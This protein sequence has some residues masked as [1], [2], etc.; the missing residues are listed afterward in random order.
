MKRKTWIKNKRGLLDPK[1]QTAIG[2]AIWLYLYLI[3]M[4]DWFTGVVSNYTD[5]QAADDLGIPQPTIRKQRYRLQNAKYIDSAKS[6]HKQYVMIGKWTN[7]RKYDG[8]VINDP[9]DVGAYLETIKS[10]HRWAVLEDEDP[11][12]VH[13]S[14]HESV[15]ESVHES[16]H[17]LSPLLLSHISQSHISQDI[18]GSL[19]QD[20]WVKALMLIKQEHYRRRAGDFDRYWSV[21]GYAGRHNGK[22]RVVCMGPDQRQ[23]LEDRGKKIAENILVGILGERVEIEFVVTGEI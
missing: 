3:D 21:T 16:V 23:W 6:R 1:H 11:E 17:E 5:G 22:Y 8:Q 12:S 2:E 10:G 18:G 7:P 15:R 9:P 14:V 13:E 19:S 20:D 4:A